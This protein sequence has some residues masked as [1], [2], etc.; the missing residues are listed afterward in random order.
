MRELRLRIELVPPPLWG[1]NLRSYLT[2]SR[3]ANLREAVRQIADFTCE[4]CGEKAS[5]ENEL[6]VNAHE[7]WRYDDARSSS[8]ATLL[9]VGC[10]C[11]LCHHIHHF[12][13][14]RN[15]I[16]SGEA[17][18]ALLERVIEHFCRVNKC[19]FDALENEERRAMQIWR[20]RADKDYALR[21][22]RFGALLGDRVATS[23]YALISAGGQKAKGETTY[24]SPWIGKVPLPITDERQTIH[25][26]PLFDSEKSRG[27]EKNAIVVDLLAIERDLSDLAMNV[28]RRA[29][30]GKTFGEFVAAAKKSAST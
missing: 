4:I 16:A 25:V 3:W 11:T 1:K 23:D 26:V 10:V 22:G 13:Q 28:A 29:W 8:T 24:T 2:D 14:L 12:G 19:D 7:D 5:R 21:W 18:P 17:Q 6:G 27:A 15:M 30:V 20:S 9:R